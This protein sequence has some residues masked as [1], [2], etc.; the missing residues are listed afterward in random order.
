M[1]KYNNLSDHDKNQLDSLIKIYD[2]SNTVNKKYDQLRRNHRSKDNK[3]KLFACA[4]YLSFSIRHFMMK[5]YDNLTC[6]SSDKTQQIKLLKIL[7]T[8]KHT[9]ILIG[10][11]NGKE[12]IIKYYKSEKKNIKYEI[13]I[14][15]KLSRDGCPLPWFTDDFTFLGARVLVMERL[16]RLS[17]SDNIYEIGSAVINQL[18]YLHKFGLHNDIKPDNIMKKKVNNKYEYY[19][20]DYGGA[21]VEKFRYG[22]K[23]WIWTSRWTSQRGG[24]A[25]QVSTPQNDFIELA[26]TLNYLHNDSGD[27]NIRNICEECLGKYNKYIMSIGIKK[28]NQIDYR[29]IQGLFVK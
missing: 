11:L 27:K 28:C 9:V 23:R 1:D 29:F 7:T 20:I 16:S 21:S 25:N 19:L 12:V 26:Y 18:S 13:N 22:Y 10:D 8:H 4:V 2:S 17:K 24:Q 15:N 6:I 3:K 14:Y 5:N